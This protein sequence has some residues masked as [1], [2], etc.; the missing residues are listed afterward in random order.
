MLCCL[1]S[2]PERL[3][4]LLLRVSIVVVFGECDD[5]LIGEWW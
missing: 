4:L 3:L 1:M 2:W 5:C